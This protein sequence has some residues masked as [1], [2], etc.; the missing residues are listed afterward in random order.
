MLGLSNGLHYSS[1]P[2]EFLPDQ[3]SGLVAW[4]DFTDISTI[5]KDDGSGGYEV[6]TDGDNISKITNKAYDGLGASSVSLATG[7]FQSTGANQPSWDE[8]AVNSKGAVHFNTTDHLFASTTVGNIT[9]DKMAGYTMD[10]D[11]VSMYW[12]FGADGATISSS[13]DQI[14]FGMTNAS[15]ATAAVTCDASDDQIYFH[16]NAD[17]TIDTGTDWPVTSTAFQAWT[18]ISN[19]TNV[20][21]FNNQGS[22]VVTDTTDYSSFNYDLTADSNKVKFSIGSGSDYASARSFRGK[23]AE[24]LIYDGAH[25]DA[26]KNLVQAYLHTKYGL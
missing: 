20:R 15:R 2:S 12:V 17:N 26:N 19:G 10:A 13:T 14:V 18:M 23:V 22:A 8:D 25:T 6:I 11:D 4:Y 7:L 1:P 24:V 9:T 16:F 5:F 21:I 3:I